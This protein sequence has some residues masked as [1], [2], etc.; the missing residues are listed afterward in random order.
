MLTFAHLKA[1]LIQQIDQIL[2]TQYNS[3]NFINLFDAF[4]LLMCLAAIFGY[5]NH[6]WFKLPTSIGLV[7][8][9]L[10]CSI[11]LVILDATIPQLNLISQLRS[12]LHQVK[13]FDALM[14]GLLCFLLFA[15]ALSVDIKSLSNSLRA[16]TLLA[17]IGVLIST[18]IIAILMYN[19]LPLLHLH[20][21]FAYCCVFG[22]LISPTDPVA[23]LAL[24][25]NIKISNRLKAKIAGESLFNDGIGIVVFLLSLAIASNSGLELQHPIF[26][27]LLL[28]L[29]QSLGGILWGFFTGY[30]AY[31]MMIR[32]TEENIEVII[33]LAI[34]MFTY[35]VSR[36][37]DVSG[38]IAVVVTGLFIGHMGVKKEVGYKNYH[39]L[40]KFWS[41]IEEILNMLLFLVIGFEFISIEFTA[42]YSLAMLIAIPTVLMARF[43]SV[44]IPISFLGIWSNYRQGTIAILSWGGI[45]GAI[46]IALALSIP[47]SE[48]KEII[49]VMTYGIVVF[50]IIV[51]GLTMKP[52][53]N[54]VMQRQNK[55]RK[56]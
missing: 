12:T 28:F 55:T 54:R 45:R 1:T 5:L 36:T 6:R 52:L 23:V 11:F 37:L 17:T 29:R 46:P 2:F 8:I 18:I 20:L 24:L 32:S 41:L 44:S 21:S 51:Q 47:Y 56:K 38:P 10:F 16:I 43:I 49:M 40:V 13:F 42:D 19:L 53:V 3:M 4:T 27:I 9:A 26:D 39:Y 25:K 50:S 34:V 7:L 33:T 31:K 30:L 48:N 14:K 15:G 35:S 22:A